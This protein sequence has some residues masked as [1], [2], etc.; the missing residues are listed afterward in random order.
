ME[1]GFYASFEFSDEFV[2][3]FEG[4]VLRAAI[5]QVTF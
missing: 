5:A 1:H 3:G 2:F 4:L